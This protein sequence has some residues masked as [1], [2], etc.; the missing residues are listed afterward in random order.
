MLTAEE[1][2]LGHQQQVLTEAAETSLP[3]RRSKIRSKA[4]V[5]GLVRVHSCLSP[6][7]RLRRNS[8]GLPSA[9][10]TY[11]ALR[12]VAAGVNSAPGSCQTA[13]AFSQHQS[14]QNKQHH[15]KA[16]HT[17]RQTEPG[18]TCLPPVGD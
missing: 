2:L 7:H 1:H 18:V 12:K 14:H 4:S 3:S 6:P 15:E 10:A 17:V 13:D 9:T 11:T 8:R 16:V 5:T